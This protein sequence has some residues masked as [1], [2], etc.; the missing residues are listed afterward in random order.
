MEALDNEIAE[1]AREAR[2]AVPDVCRGR[3]FDHRP[4]HCRD[5]S[6]SSAASWKLNE[7][8][9]IVGLKDTTTTDVTGIEM[10]RKLLDQARRATTSA[11]PPRY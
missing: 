7:T 1:P 6:L 8:V 5:G 2:Q 4:R 11:S 9:E 10:F 3:L